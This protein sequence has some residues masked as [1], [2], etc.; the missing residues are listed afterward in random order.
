MFGHKVRQPPEG[1]VAAERE[2][3]ILAAHEVTPASFARVKKLGLGTRRAIA[4]RLGD[5]QVA[6]VGER[7]VEVAFTLPA[8]AYATAVLRELVKAESTQ[9]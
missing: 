3:T 1:T 8:G 5:I 6:P 9:S 2:N 7:A 4:V